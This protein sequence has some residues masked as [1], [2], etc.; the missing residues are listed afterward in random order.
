[1]EKEN[2][3]NSHSNLTEKEKI[4]AEKILKSIL[5]KIRKNPRIMESIEHEAYLRF[6]S[7]SWTDHSR[8]ISRREAVIRY[9]RL[10]VVQQRIEEIEKRME[11]E[12]KIFRLFGIFDDFI[13]YFASLFEKNTKKKTNQSKFE[14]YIENRYKHNAYRQEYGL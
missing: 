10:L 5:A 14:K 8:E 12:N 4:Y 1:M 13:D 3:N 11:K 6:T 7:H 9:I 2:K